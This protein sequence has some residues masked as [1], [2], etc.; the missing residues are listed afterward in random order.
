MYFDSCFAARAFQTTYGGGG[1]A[2]VTKLNPA[3][4][5]LVYSTYIGG[6]GFDSAVGGTE[7]D[8]S[9]NAYVMGY[10]ESS[11]FPTTPDAFQSGLQGFTDAFVSKLNADGS[12]LLFSTYFGESGNT[13]V[14]AA[15]VALDHSGN[16]YVTGITINSATTPGAFQT[17]YGG[18]GD[19][20]VSKFSFGTPF[21]SFSGK[22]ELDVDAGSFQLNAPFKLGAGGSINPPTEPVSLTIGTYSVTIP[23]GSFVRHKPGYAFESVINGASL[24]VLIKFGSTPGS[25]Q[26]L[27]EGK[28]ADL[29]GTT[30]PVTV[31][32]SIGNDLGTT[33]IHAEF[34]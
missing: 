3:G 11:N 32:L 4:S 31:T 24:E 8:A 19:A 9:G 6:N 18:G 12:T 26:F 7:V 16:A 15:G 2:F 23:A 21:S 28:G 34:E 33:Q 5:A 22:L 25:Y 20:F 17:T 27:A 29:K 10:T 14:V 1:D 13:D 30:N